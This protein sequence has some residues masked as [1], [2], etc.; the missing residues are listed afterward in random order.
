MMLVKEYISFP[1]GVYFTKV[2]N[3]CPFV[4]Q[5]FIVLSLDPVMTYCP[6][7]GS[8]I[9]FYTTTKYVYTYTHTH[10]NNKMLPRLRLILGY[11]GMN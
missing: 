7:T 10:E 5:I 11:T 9:L 3:N 1:L 2:C 6:A 8:F 4:V